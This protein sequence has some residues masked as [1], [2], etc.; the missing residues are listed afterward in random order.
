MMQFM[1]LQMI[2]LALLLAFPALA[3][4]LPGALR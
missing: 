3:L 2:G 4:W 1:V